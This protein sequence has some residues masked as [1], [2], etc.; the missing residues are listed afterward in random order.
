MKICYIGDS[1]CISHE[2]AVDRCMESRSLYFH[3]DQVEILSLYFKPMLYTS[4]V[5]FFARRERMSI[6]LNIVFL[7][8]GNKRVINW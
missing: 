3:K 6:R 8:Q 1:F 7:N 5:H 4:H 2:F